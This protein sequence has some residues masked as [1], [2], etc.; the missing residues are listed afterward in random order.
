MYYKFVIDR[1]VGDFSHR[2]KCY[3]AIAALL[4]TAMNAA[5]QD[6]QN[7]ENRQAQ[8]DMLTRQQNFQRELNA[9]SALVQMQSLKKAGLSPNLLSGNPAYNATASLGD[10]SS[11]QAPQIDVSA[12]SSLLQ[13]Q[14]LVD[15]QARKDNAEAK[16]QEIENARQET[17]DRHLDAYFKDKFP[18]FD[19]PN[20]V[21]SYKNYNKGTID[22]QKLEREWEVRATEL[23]ALDVQ[24]QF[25]KLVNDTKLA[26]SATV[27]AVA[28]MPLL[29]RRKL[30]N[31]VLNLIKDRKVMDSVIKLND[32][33]TSLAASQEALNILEEE[34]TRN[35]NIHELITK[36]LGDG[37]MA[38]AAHFITM[39]VGAVT[40]NMR[41]GANLSKF[42]GK[43]RSTN[44]NTNTNSNTNRSTS[45]SRV[46]VY[47][48]D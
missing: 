22:A 3:G 35:S 11:Q 25:D 12:I 13:Q 26:N 31:E 4:G 34:I 28:D 42:S 24:Y 1:P 33:H 10:S 48:H 30:Y 29:E 23:D 36:Y 20:A 16:A 37:A 5:Y 2:F 32:A 27:Q 9:N 43:T 46:H 19:D 44:T 41:F 18:A 15:A 17:L 45:N 14:P 6:K 39:L 47:K 7:E 8:N 38:D 21:G 40:G